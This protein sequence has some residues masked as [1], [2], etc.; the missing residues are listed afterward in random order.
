M[1]NWGE[2]PDMVLSTPRFDCAPLAGVMEAQDASS[3]PSPPAD[4]ASILLH[5]G[6]VR[7]TWTLGADDTIAF[8]VEAFRSSRYLA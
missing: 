8:H 5:A 2:L 3:P 7:L 1:Y 6:R 4:P